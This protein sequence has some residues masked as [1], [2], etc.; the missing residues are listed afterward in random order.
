MQESFCDSQLFTIHSGIVLLCIVEFLI[1][2]CYWVKIFGSCVLVE[3]YGTNHL[4]ASIGVYFNLSFI[5][6]IIDF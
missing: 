5:T 2:I 3:K 6:T 4:G 1:I